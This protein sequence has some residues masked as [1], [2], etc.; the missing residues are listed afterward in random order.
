MASGN[1]VPQQVGMAGPQT[2]QP[3]QPI[4]TSVSRS[5]PLFTPGTGVAGGQANDLFAK[6][7]PT[8]QSGPKLSPPAGGGGKAGGIPQQPSVG[9]SRS[10]PFS[11]AGSGY[12]Y[13]DYDPAT[14][15]VRHNQ[16]GIAGNTDMGRVSVADLMNPENV[17]A[18]SKPFDPAKGPQFSFDPRGTYYDEGFASAFNQYQNQAQP[19]ASPMPAGGGVADGAQMPSQDYMR[20]LR[21][22]QTQGGSVGENATKKL[23]EA[24]AIIDANQSQPVAGS[25]GNQQQQ[26]QQAPN[27]NQ[28]AA[29]GIQ[30][31][32][33]GAA[34]EMNYRPMN[35]S[36]VLM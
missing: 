12:S 33:A 2:M 26:Q 19:A 3:G 16:S 22:F 25:G 13:D 9:G 28:S 4:Q 21:D 29:R 34:R 23:A 7:T 32:M 24:Q 30:G 20:M 17:R 14:N 18:R 27:I 31:A 10:E 8:P 1:G 15:T 35:V 5:G 36:R 6:R 11:H